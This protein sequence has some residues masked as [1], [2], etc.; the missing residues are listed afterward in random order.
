MW[1]FKQM[2]D[3]DIFIKGSR[4]TLYCPHCATPISNFEVAMDADN[5]KDIS[6]CARYL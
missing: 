3:K 4:V 1:V 6:G 5:Y 2:Y